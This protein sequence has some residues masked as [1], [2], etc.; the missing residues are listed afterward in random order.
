MEDG[1]TTTPP[2]PRV[3]LPTSEMTV[4]SVELQQSS[5]QVESPASESMSTEWTNEKHSLYLKSMEASFVNDLYNSFDLLGWRSQ[6]QHSSDS[7]LSG[8][9]HASTRSSSGQFKV[10]R[11][12]CWGKID[13]E[14]HESQLD[15]A[16]GSGV[17]LANPWIRH[18]RPSFRHQI[19]TS[20]ALQEKSAI[21][22]PAVH[23]NGKMALTSTALAANLEQFP[24]RHA[25]LCDDDSADSNTEV[26]D[27][28]FIDDDIEEEKANH[29]C[30]A[31]R[32]KA[33]VVAAPS[34]D[35]VVPFGKF[36]VIADL[37]KN[38][39]SPERERSCS[40]S[41]L[42]STEDGFP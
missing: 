5:S 13:F 6:R 27:Q 39:F 29:P 28:N 31:K 38:Y 24:A 7:K 9:K 12:G 2:P 20:S 35:Q 42:K 25:H 30:N 10:L 18:F 19:V 17:L 40:S 34:N 23:V 21:G 11:G 41:D 14:R 32:I 15:K 36:P 4:D 16:D 33:S 26:T 37:T 22:N 1:T 3:T 8:Q